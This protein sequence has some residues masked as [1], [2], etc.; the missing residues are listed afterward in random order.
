MLAFIRELKTF[1][2]LLLSE[3]QDFNRYAA[4]LHKLIQKFELNG[5]TADLYS[6]NL[7]RFARWK[8]PVGL[9]LKWKQH[10]MLH[11]F[12]YAT[13]KDSTLYLNYYSR[14]CKSLDIEPS[15]SNQIQQNRQP[16]KQQQSDNRPK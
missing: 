9:L 5:Y 4:F 2:K 10:C 7:I 6:G 8:L 3:P 11:D 1:D 14:A 16:T 12:D 13:L 15:T